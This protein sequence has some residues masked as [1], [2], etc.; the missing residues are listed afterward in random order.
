MDKLILIL[1]LAVALGW[2]LS[3][4]AMAGEALAAEAPPSHTLSNAS[5]KL[6][7]YLPDADRGFYRSTRFD[8]SGMIDRVEYKGHVFYS[9]WKQTHDPAQGTDD[10]VGP[11]EE[12]GMQVLPLGY[13]DAKPGETFMKIGIGHILKPE[14]SRFRYSQPYKIAKPGEWK[15][16]K[17]DDFVEMQ[18]DL[19][20]DRGYGY[21]YTKR[22]SLLKDAPGFLI[23]H[24]LKNTGT[25]PI[26]TD[27]YNHNFTMIDSAKI[28]PAY[29][30]TF[31]FVPVINQ[32]ERATLQPGVMKIDGRDLVFTADVTRPLWVRLDGF[33][34]ETP[35]DNLI[36][37]RNVK[38]G[39]AIKITGDRPLARV[40]FYAAETA[41]CPEPFVQLNLAP[42]AEATWQYRYELVVDEGA[43]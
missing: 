37:I 12:F 34:P 41:A 1:T 40:A 23:A 33:K 31:G 39:A 30:L 20:N 8:W 10:V 21:Q 36:I 18:Q 5:V 24:R 38:S 28:G 15:I 2:G 11:A 16:N 43:R 29:R 17:G 35:A 25:K 26:D 9:Y 7:M 14:E 6:S 3:A 22:I 19:S 32:T 27:H 42:G 4:A 13:A